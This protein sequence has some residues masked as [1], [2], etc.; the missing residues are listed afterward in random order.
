MALNKVEICGVNTSRLPVL[1][2]E[3]K[4]ALFERIKKG[5]TEARERYIKGNLRLVLSVIK[6][7]SSSNENAD[8]LFQIGCVGLMKAID[9]FDTT[10]NVKFST[11]AVPMIIGEIRRYLRDNN[12]I[13]VSR[14][15]RDTA[16]KA[17]YAKENYMK[18][19]LKEPT[20]NEIAE[21]IGIEKE[22]IVY[23]LDAIQSPVSLY[24]PVYT[25]G[26][27]TLYVMDQISENLSLKEALKRLDE[28][29]RNIVEMRFYEGRTQM[30]VAREIG[31]SQAQVS[32]LEKHALK[33]MRTYL[34]A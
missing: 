27:D 15:L 33:S 30:E 16:Y 5:D 8:D 11:Y 14:S 18:Q 26:G 13:R 6:R 2:N 4:E 7:F 1:T 21:E 28:R 25:E 24:E 10:L 3:E 20:L 34:R 17:I 29:E 19:N 22:E 23:A 32:R 9:N 31:I 12:S